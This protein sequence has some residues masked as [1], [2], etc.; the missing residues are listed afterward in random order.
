MDHFMRTPL[1]EACYFGLVFDFKKKG[2]SGRRLWGDTFYGQQSPHFYDVS[3]G[4]W[5][6]VI[7]TLRSTETNGCSSGVS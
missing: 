4:P 6:W 1:M 5:V 7:S 2:R 3:I